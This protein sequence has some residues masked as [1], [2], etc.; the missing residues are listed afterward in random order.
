[1]P[2]KRV[3]YPASIWDEEVVT[4]AVLGVAGGKPVHVHSVYR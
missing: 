4:A 3:L 2:K 1:M